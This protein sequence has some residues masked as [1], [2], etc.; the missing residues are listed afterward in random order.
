MTTSANH[1]MAWA[2]LGACRGEDQDLFYPPVPPEKITAAHVALARPI[3]QACPVYAACHAHAVQ[4]ESDGIWAAT[5]PKDRRRLRKAMGIP[6]MVPDV[7][8]LTADGRSAAEI[9]SIL[10]ID[11]RTVVRH[12]TARR[13]TA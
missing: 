5:S 6:D 2:D 3:C 4:R 7:A 12:R 11:K 9:A 10:G 13:K 1:P 8:E